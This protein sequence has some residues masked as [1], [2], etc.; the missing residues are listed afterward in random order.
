MLKELNV[1]IKSGETV[2][3]V[4]RTGSGKSTLINTLLQII[5]ITVG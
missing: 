1:H 5:P 2:G 4:G 3:V